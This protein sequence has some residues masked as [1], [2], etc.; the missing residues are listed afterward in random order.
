MRMVGK[1][2]TVACPLHKNST[3]NLETG[4]TDNWR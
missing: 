3:W 4:I 2:K 1:K